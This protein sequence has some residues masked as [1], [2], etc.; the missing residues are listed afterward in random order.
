[1][2]AV[3]EGRRR[4]AED[5]R[6]APQQESDPTAA[7]GG[8]REGSEWQRSARDEGAKP[9]TIAGHRNRRA[10]RPPPAAGEGRGASGSGRRGTKAQSR[11]QSPGT[12]TEE[13][14]D[15]NP[16]SA[17]RLLPAPAAHWKPLV[18]L[19]KSYENSLKTLS[20]YHKLIVSRST[21]SCEIN[22]ICGQTWTKYFCPY[23]YNY[24]IRSSVFSS[25][26]FHSDEY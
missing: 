21:G 20:F 15:A 25:I 4:K 6:R 18:W 16:Q 13:R 11:R 14:S 24:Y 3:G 26:L 2:A 23:P 9:R 8:R 1:V 17:C 22:E 5:N 7:G 10:T 12:A 19:S